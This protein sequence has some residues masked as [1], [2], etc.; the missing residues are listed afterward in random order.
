MARKF[1]RKL[2]DKKGNCY[3]VEIPHDVNPES[4]EDIMIASQEGIVKLQA[5]KLD[6]DTYRLPNDNSEIFNGV[7]VFSFY[8]KL[9]VFDMPD[10]KQEEFGTVMQHLIAEARNQKINKMRLTEFEGKP[11]KQDSRGYYL[12]WSVPCEMCR[13]NIEGVRRLSMNDGQFTRAQSFVAKDSKVTQYR[14]GS[15]LRVCGDCSPTHLTPEEAGLPFPTVEEVTAPVE[16]K[17]EPVE[18]VT[19]PKTKDPLQELIEL[20]NYKSDIPLEYLKGYVNGVL[21]GLRGAKHEA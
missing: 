17:R 15:K 10:L 12:D 1:T 21:K 20:T 5:Y 2:I 7:K 9:N 16:V 14:P 8:K 6:G 13:K 11:V 3:C 19:R 4:I 18:V